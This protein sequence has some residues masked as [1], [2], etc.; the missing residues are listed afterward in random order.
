MRLLECPAHASLLNACITEVLEQHQDLLP[1]L[2]SLIILAS[3][4]DHITKR[5]I[6]NALT[7]RVRDL[8]HTAYILPQITTL[9]IWALE[10]HTPDLTTNEL[11]EALDLVLTL[12]DQKSDTFAHLNDANPWAVAHEMLSLFDEL[13]LNDTTLPSDQQEFT[14]QLRENYELSAQEEAATPGSAPFHLETEAGIVHLLWQAWDHSSSNIVSLGKAYREA[15][16]RLPDNLPEAPAVYL[17]GHEYLHNAEILALEQVSQHIPVTLLTLAQHLIPCSGEQLHTDNPLS[18]RATF[19]TQAFAGPEPSIRD[20][21]LACREHIPESELSG[22]LNLL[23]A[24]ESEPHAA[25]IELQIRKWLRQGAKKI[26][27][28]TDDRRLARRVHALLVRSSIDMSDTFG[29]GLSTTS[30]ASLIHHW[31]DCVEEDFH[32]LLL[33]SVLKSPFVTLPGTDDPEA[34]SRETLITRLEQYLRKKNTFQSLE[35]YRA[36]LKSNPDEPQPELEQL[37]DWVEQAAKPMQIH[38]PITAEQYFGGLLESLKLLGCEEPLRADEVGA[39]ILH[40][41]GEIRFD[42]QNRDETL[43]ARDWRTILRTRLEKENHEF[44]AHNSEVILI[45]L[46]QAHLVEFDYL[47]VAGMDS[48]HYPGNISNATVFNDTVRANLGLR[49]RAD[50]QK[51]RLQRFVSLLIQS[52]EA[53]LIYQKKDQE[54]DYHPSPWWSQL[55]TFHHL[56]HGQESSLHDQAL[57]HL[58]LLSSLAQPKEDASTSVSDPSEPELLPAEISASGHQSLIDCP[59]Q[60]F[61]SRMLGLREQPTVHETMESSEMGLFVHKCLE[62]FNSGDDDLPD[63]PWVGPIG[64]RREEATRLLHDIGAHILQQTHAARH[65]YRAYL[66]QWDV[67]IERYLDLQERVAERH[68]EANEIGKS[69]SLDEQLKL[70][71]RLDRLDREENGSVVID[72]KTGSSIISKTQIQNGEKVQLSTYALLLPE[73]D[74][75]EYWWLGQAEQNKRLTFQ[76][77]EDL[78]DIAQQVRER[79]TCLYADLHNG[80]AMPANG[81]TTTCQRCFAKGICRKDL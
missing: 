22:S 75:A 42:L 62:I 21:A 6:Q 11:S 60:F 54:Q 49:Q 25:A 79:L 50:N 44:L 5:A 52:R 19:I 41:L 66:A 70:C 10:Q 71:G 24:E 48:R 14:Q 9:R 36:T 12:K 3:S 13:W 39:D 58:S 18:P 29:W 57:A 51:L 34:E 40:H 7:R 23:V 1:D 47:I 63:T 20:R 31:L 15:L 28:V 37:L 4:P 17:C 8:G 74:K 68:I 72:Y 69:I 77:G 46:E 32:Y 27:L 73:A 56:V 80:E 43:S 33:L 16:R 55:S 35:Q 78:Q 45:S 59:Y 81:D 67:F 64:E 61:I 2:S 76:A 38:K 53:L 30:A 65:A 26:G